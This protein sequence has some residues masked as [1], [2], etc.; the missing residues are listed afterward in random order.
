MNDVTQADLDR[1]F[2]RIG[3]V[4]RTARK[5]G[6]C[7]HGRRYTGG[8]VCEERIKPGDKYVAGPCNFVAGPWSRDR[9]CMGC[10]RARIHL[11]AWIDNL[12][13]AA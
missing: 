5:E 8:P 13:S 11:E 1:L 4:I 10:V 6:Q 12:P 9:Y 7:Q 3:A 2:P